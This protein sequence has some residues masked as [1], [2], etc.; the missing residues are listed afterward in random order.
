VYDRA[1]NGRHDAPSGS[2]VG[3]SGAAPSLARASGPLAPESGA[4]ESPGFDPLSDVLR[5]VRLTA[6]VFFE[7]DAT[8]PWVIEVPDLSA[9]EAFHRAALD[10]GFRD[11]GGPGKR[12]EYHPGY[13]GA[14]VLDPDG[15][16]VEAVFHDR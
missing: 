11:N 7:V 2:V 3:S 9:V 5:A 8:S 6:A 1:V 4:V 14:F 16:N 15:N 10:A 13:Y 12:P